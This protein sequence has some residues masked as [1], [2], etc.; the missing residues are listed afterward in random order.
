MSEADEF[1]VHCA[2]DD[3]NEVEEAYKNEITYSNERLE[4][5]LDEI[6]AFIKKTQKV[7]VQTRDQPYNN[8][9]EKIN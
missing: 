6:I 4:G 1:L 2:V 3:A 9:F 7:V 8:E 5:V